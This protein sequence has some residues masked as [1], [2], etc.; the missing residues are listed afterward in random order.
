MISLFLGEIK[1]YHHSLALK[2]N[3]HHVS[4]MKVLVTGASGYIGSHLCKRLSD[5]QCQWAAL[6]RRSAPTNQRIPKAGHIFE[7]DPGT[8]ATCI[9]D[10]EPQVVVHCATLF[11]ARHCAKQ[12]PALVESNIGF[13]LRVLDALDSKKTAF[14]NLGSA[15]Q[16]SGSLVEMPSPRSL[17]AAT[18]QAFE[19]LA[20]YYCAARRLG[21]L[22][23]KLADTYGPLDWRGKI[24]SKLIT[25]AVRRETIPFPMSSGNQN[26]HLLHIDDV[27]TGIIRGIDAA[28]SLIDTGQFLSR[29]LRPRET[30]SP[31]DL[32]S[33]LRA[34]RPDLPFEVE[35]GVLPDRPMD[36]V[37]PWL[38]GVVLEEWS[39]QIELPEGLRQ[40]I[41]AEEIKSG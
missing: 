32:V 37:G 12:I 30:T 23:L 36:T 11:V 38:G 24:V 28:A 19:D 3:P 18:K 16:N 26:M 5:L 39:P 17:Y 33:V 15:W 4:K 27:V 22:T 7:C 13:G 35:F 31:R 6:A 9:K 21:F 29:A 40:A 14:V 25:R 20:K 1:N 8:E 41:R 2:I 34:V 10:F